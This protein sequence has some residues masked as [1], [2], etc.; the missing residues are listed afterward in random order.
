MSEIKNGLGEKW[1]RKLCKS[2]VVCKDKY[3]TLNGKEE[4]KQFNR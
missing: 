1:L 4:N 3:S 2:T